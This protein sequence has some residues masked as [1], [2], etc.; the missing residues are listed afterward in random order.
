MTLTLQAKIVS[1]SELGL[2]QIR[3]KDVRKLYDM[4]RIP[5]SAITSVYRTWVSQD[6]ALIFE[7]DDRHFAMYAAKRGNA[8]YRERVES[9][10]EG[11]EEVLERSVRVDAKRAA[12][13]TVFF[14]A[15]YDPRKTSLPH[16]WLA[17]GPDWNRFM[18]ALRRRYGRVE[19]LRVWQSHESG[20]PHVHAILVFE[21]HH[22]K[23]FIGKDKKTIRVDEAPILQ[24]YWKPGLSDVLSP[25]SISDVAKHILRYITR[26]LIT[27][28]PGSDDD[29]LIQ[30]FGD[31]GVPLALKEWGEFHSKLDKT[32]ALTWLF[33]KRSFGITKRLREALKDIRLDS[34]HVHNSNTG[35]R[36]GIPASDYDP[37]KLH[38]V[39]CCSW[40]S[41]LALRKED[42]GFGSWG[43]ELTGIPWDTVIRVKDDLDPE[44]LFCL[45][46]IY[47][48]TNTREGTLEPWV[49]RERVLDYFA[50]RRRRGGTFS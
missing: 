23:T 12:S 45:P 3:L 33:R 21:N 42:T 14:T 37:S 10:F 44:A 8:A 47:I 16:A 38:F 29:S 39:G 15:T 48:L 24:G 5:L 32:L 49:Y 50:G 19:A 41:A 43:L 36:L 1:A 46:A 35:T 18:S 25:V 11:L 20:Y 6:E 13:N 28:R 9:R 31:E 4:G 30:R 34:E 40:K 27:D 26:F 22:F 17:V 7:Y 2:L